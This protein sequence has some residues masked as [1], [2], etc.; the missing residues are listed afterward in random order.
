[1]IALLLFCFQSSQ[2]AQDAPKAFGQITIDVSKQ[3]PISPYIY[4]ANFP[5]NSKDPKWVQFAKGFTVARMGGNRTTAYN[6]E[7][8]ASNAGNDYRYQNDGYMGT[9]DEP[10]KAVSDFYKP[11]AANGSVSILTV[12]CAGYVAADKGPDGDVNKTPN[13]LEA[14]FNKSFASKPGGSYSLT[15]NTNDRSVYQ[16]EF[17]NFVEK[18]KPAG[19]KTWYSLDNEPDL[20]QSTH[21]RIVPQNV[22][23]AGILERGI[24]YATAVKKVAPGSLVFGPASY[25][26]HG[27]RTFQ[28][29]PDRNDRDF[30]EFYLAKMKEAEVRTG[31]RLLDVLDIHWY[32]EAQGGGNRI[33]GEKNNAETDLA[34]AQ[35]GRSLWDPSYVESS[36]IADSLGKKPISLLPRTIGQISKNY[37]GTKLGITEYDFGG[38]SEPSGMVTQADVLGIYGRF[39]VFAACHWGINHDRPAQVAGFGAFTNFDGK[40]GKFGSIGLNVVGE[41]PAAN[42]VYASIDP[43]IKGRIVIVAVNKLAKEQAIRVSLSIPKGSKAVGYRAN[44]KNPYEP[45]SLGIDY[46]SSG[47]L[48][49]LPAYGVGTIEIRT[50]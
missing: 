21:V 27:Y 9:T 19:A 16:D 45:D 46:G 29:A 6:W 34:R 8:N 18:S 7:T 20:W 47:V 5:F 1:M 10:G 36:W 11:A 24:A 2:F 28:D 25:G 32:P 48:F 40:G 35:A 49:S 31:K 12:P 14:R 44:V 39:G 17:V 41:T 30:L 37:P 33:C 38:G 43:T 22:G 15:P 13:Y 4:G 3:S 50:Q 23:F 42:S 26:W